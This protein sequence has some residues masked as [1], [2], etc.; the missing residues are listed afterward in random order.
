MKAEKIT[1]RF[2]E[3]LGSTPMVISSFVLVFSWVAV[4]PLFHFSSSWE[5]FINTATTII[6]FLMVFIIQNSQNRD[7]VAIQT[8]LDALLSAVDKADNALVGIE[9]LSHNELKTERDRVRKSVE[10]V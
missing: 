10:D 1:S 6:T 4:G 3:F 9:D 7:S 5:L 2:T 8:K